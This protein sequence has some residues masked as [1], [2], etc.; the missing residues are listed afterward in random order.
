M[1]PVKFPPGHWPVCK[2]GGGYCIRQVD[3]LRDAGAPWMA[4]RLARR[5][6]YSSFESLV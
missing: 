2:E 1:Y 6:Q 4:R 3:D 5:D